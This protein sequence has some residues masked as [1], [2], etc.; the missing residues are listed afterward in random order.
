[1]FKIKQILLATAITAV[2]VACGGG[3]SANVNPPAGMTPLMAT[4]VITGFGSIYINGTHFQTTSAKIRKNGQTVAQSQLAVGQVAR[5]K[6]S[7]DASGMSG[8]ADEVDV[9][10]S[11]VGPISTIDIVNSVLTVLGQTVKVNAGT[12]F[13]KDIQ[14]ADLTGLTMGEV[15]EVDGLIDSSG[16]IAATRIEPASAGAPLQVLGSVASLNSAAHTFMINTLVVDYSSATLTGFTG[17]APS[18]GDMVEVQGTTFDATTTTLT[19]AQVTR[20][21]SD[22]EEAG[23]GRDIEREGLITRFASATDFDVTGNPVTTNSSTEFR[24]GSASDLALNVKVEVEGTLDSSN[25]LV[26]AVVDFE[27]NGSVE[28]QSQATQVD[29]TA[30]TLTLLGVQVTVNASTRFEDDS[31]AAIAMFNLSNVAVGDTIKVHGYES[32]AGS[33]QVL[34]TR[35]EREPP[36]ATVIVQGPFTA[37]TSPD[38]TVLGITIDA[39]AAAI[40]D[41]HGGTLDPA[42]FLTRAIGHGVEVEGTVSGDVVTASEIAIDDQSGDEN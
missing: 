31:S 6:G 33:G 21:M 17:G 20:Q 13:S 11:V 26:A 16:A 15:I 30:G 35:L 18:D 29:T 24:N 1:M 38:F 27:H 10:E 32:P 3:G 25:V 39:S 41:G 12:S 22:Q 37:G 2:I 14:P 4:G 9:D 5:I 40:S 36:S 8:V 28:L 7:K 42:T 23:D 19:A 34:A